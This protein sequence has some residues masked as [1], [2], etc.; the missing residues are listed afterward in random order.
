LRHLCINLY[1]CKKKPN[2]AIHASGLPESASDALEEMF[3]AALQAI[4][5]KENA[6]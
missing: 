4:R 2:T 5:Q 6:K 1:G 3:Q